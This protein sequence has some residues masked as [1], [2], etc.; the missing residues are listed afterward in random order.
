M[1]ITDLK[2]YSAVLKLLRCGADVSPQLI[3]EITGIS[4]STVYRK[5][6]NYYLIENQIKRRE[7][8]KRKIK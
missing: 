6:R 7:N 3:S 5:I 2:I 4:L 8:G 1:N